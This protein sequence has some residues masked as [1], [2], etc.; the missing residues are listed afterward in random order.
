MIPSPQEG[1]AW[2]SFTGHPPHEQWEFTRSL[3]CSSTQWSYYVD[4]GGFRTHTRNLRKVNRPQGALCSLPAVPPYP[5]LSCDTPNCSH[6]TRLRSRLPS[7]RRWA[8]LC[9]RL[10]CLARPM[11]C[12]S[13]WPQVRLAGLL[14]CARRAASETRVRTCVCAYVCVC[15]QRCVTRPIAASEECSLCCMTARAILGPDFSG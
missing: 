5:R 3:A 8:V 9:M 14:P 15:G 2:T 4:L 11:W 7:R 13:C 10:L 1:G 6:D 12:K